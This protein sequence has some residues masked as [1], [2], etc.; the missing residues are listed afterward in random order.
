MRPVGVQKLPQYIARG[1][2]MHMEPSQGLSS[3]KHEAVQKGQH[4]FV[5]C[6][7]QIVDFQT[8]ATKGMKPRLT[9]LH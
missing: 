4:C 7:D 2:K 8:A 1:V 6:L 5:C 3:W 9:Y